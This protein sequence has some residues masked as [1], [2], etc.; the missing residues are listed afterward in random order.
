MVLKV[1]F[2]LALSGASLAQAEPLTPADSALVQRATAYLQH[3]TTAQG[4]FTQ[5]NP[6]GQ[7]ATGTFVIQRPGK[8]RFDYDPPSGLTIA[9]DG[10]R[11]AVLDR[12]LKTIQASPLGLTPL[13]LFLAKDIRLDRG[14]D[15]AKVT[16]TPGGFIVVASDAHKKAQGQIALDFTGNPIALTGWTITDAG[17]GATRVRLTDFARSPPR[18]A[19]FF[20]LQDPRP[21]GAA[22]TF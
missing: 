11:V 1:V 16:R 12:R 10:H 19:S 9:S 8:A 5:T 15:V 6:R 22:P 21:T 14:V 13:S 4:R 2:L 18:E 3:L 17:G 7:T 20:V